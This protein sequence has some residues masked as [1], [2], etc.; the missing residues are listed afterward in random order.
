MNG[1]NS[2]TDIPVS[3]THLDVYKRQPQHLLKDIEGVAKI[4][5]NFKTDK[6]IKILLL[7]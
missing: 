1:A 2:I 5:D 4:Y 6:N 3:Y 7:K